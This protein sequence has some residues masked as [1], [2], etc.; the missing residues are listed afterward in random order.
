MAIFNGNIFQVKFIDKKK[1]MI[2]V[3]YKNEDRIIAHSVEVDW[4]LQDFQDLIE[5]IDLEDIERETNKINKDIQDRKKAEVSQEVDRR[6]QN[7]FHEKSSVIETLIQE[8]IA[9]REDP[10]FLFKFKSELFK[11][12]E[13]TK[14]TNLWRKRQ[15]KKSK[16]A[17][18]ILSLLHKVI[19]K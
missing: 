9:N 2:E 18:H 15:M 5:E 4:E 16:D 7:G 3:L 1:T 13:V 11:M 8:V 12:P 19:K 17:L 10:S 14:S 6:L